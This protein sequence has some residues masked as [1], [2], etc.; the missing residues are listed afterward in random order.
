MLKRRLMPLSAK[1]VVIALSLILIVIGCFAAQAYQQRIFKY[2]YTEEPIR[3]LQVLSGVTSLKAITIDEYCM[4]AF[5]ITVMVQT[6]QSSLTNST[7]LQIYDFINENPGIQFRAICAGLCLPVGLVQYYLNGLTKAGLISFIRDGRYKRFF[8]SKKFS[9]KEMAAISLLRH[10]T[11]KKI[12][13]VL[14]FKKQ[15]T[16]CRLASEVS[17]TS[18][19]L[20]WQIKAMRNTEFILHLNKGL[21]TIYYLDEP[22]AL[23]LQKYL[24]IVN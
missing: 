22:S 3:R 15:L 21:K 5:P 13:E 20:T 9:K 6:A 12:V 10:K 7:C 24:A 17:I 14:L 11:V 8:I 18:Q 19:A 23:M 2:S 16:H 4:F 1:R